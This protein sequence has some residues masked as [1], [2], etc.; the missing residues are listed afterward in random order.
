MVITHYMNINII[1]F[2]SW[3]F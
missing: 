2:L 3:S 1:I